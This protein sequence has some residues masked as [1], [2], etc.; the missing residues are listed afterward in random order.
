M[1]IFA[2]HGIDLCLDEVQDTDIMNVLKKG[3]TPKGGVY[4]GVYNKD[5]NAGSLLD[6]FQSCCEHTN[7]NTM[8]YHQG[9]CFLIT[10]NVTVSD[11]CSA[12]P[13]TSDKFRDTYMINV[14]SVG[15]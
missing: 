3:A 9:S 10:C 5:K 13:R 4:A 15:R 2:G 7:C 8:F 12:V 14:R 6:C 11:A 1:P